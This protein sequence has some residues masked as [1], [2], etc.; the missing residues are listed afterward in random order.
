MNI[1]MI[2]E[3]R[4][5]KKCMIHVECSKESDGSIRVLGS[6][7]DICAML[8]LLIRYLKKSGMP[9]K[10]IMRVVADGLADEEEDDD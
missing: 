1:K 3:Y 6:G 7:V 9:E 10:L 5:N 2:S 4:D 8:L